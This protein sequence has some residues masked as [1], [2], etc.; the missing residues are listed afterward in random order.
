MRSGDG[1]SERENREKRRR[2]IT[3]PHHRLTGKLHLPVDEVE[4]EEVS[5]VIG[6]E[7]EAE[8]VAPERG[9]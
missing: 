6:V 4:G 7:V 9:D 1:V 3:L 5:L 8:S 2:S